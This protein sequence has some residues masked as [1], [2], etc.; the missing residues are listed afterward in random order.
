MK[1]I[2]KTRGLSRRRMLATTAGA[3]A[4]SSVLSTPLYAAGKRKLRYIAFIN[5]NT[6]WFGCDR[7]V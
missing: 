4:A 5:R 6:V 3:V 7:W 2:T 1:N